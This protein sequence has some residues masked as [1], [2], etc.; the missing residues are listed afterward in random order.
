M[1]MTRLNL[2]GYGDENNPDFTLWNK[3]DVATGMTWDL[4]QGWILNSDPLESG[5]NLNF[6]L[7]GSSVLVLSST[8]VQITGDFDFATFSGTIDGGLF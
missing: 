7:N 6:K 2:G 4:G 8:G 1:S 5:G 3:G